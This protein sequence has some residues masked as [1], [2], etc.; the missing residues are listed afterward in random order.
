M[1]AP[2]FPAFAKQF[3]DARHRTSSGRLIQIRPT[4][5]NSGLIAEELTSRAATGQPSGACNQAPGGCQT[6]ELPTL[7][8]PAADH[9]FSAINHGAGQTVIDKSDTTLLAT[10]YVGIAMQREMARC[11]GWPGREIGF[12]DVLALRNEPRGWASCPTAKTEWGQKVLMV[13]SDPFSSSTGRSVLFS[14]YGIA[15]GKQPEALRVDD[16]RDPN[17]LAYI[18]A[19]QSA[20]DHYVPDST[21]V[22]RKMLEGP[23][24][25]QFFFFPENNFVS[26]KRGL[27][28]VQ[29]PG[30]AKPR[31][32]DQDMV[33]IYPKEGAPAN[34]HSA[35]MV[36]ASWVTAEQREAAQQWVNFLLED[37]QQRALVERGFRPA[38]NVPWEDVINPSYGVDPR[39]PTV[40]TNPD[41]VDAAAAQVIL[42]SWGEVKR[43]GVATF[44]VDTSGSMAGAKMDQAKKGM[45]SVLDQI[46]PRNLVGFLTF[47][48]QVNTRVTIGSVTE[49]RYQIRDVVEAMRPSG[50]TALYDAIAEAIA[51]TDAA[52][53]GLDAIRGVVVL[54]DGKAN[55][56]RPLDSVITMS[57]DERPVGSCPA[58]ETGAGCTDQAGRPAKF[59]QILGE[60]LAIPTKHDIHVFFVGIGGDA[61]LQ[62]GRILASATGAT[63]VTTTEKNLSTVLETFGK[64]F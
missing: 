12:S 48:D 2:V 13:Y 30:E 45:I 8:T 59:E 49:N 27:V 55:R 25:G 37:A 36:H 19:F 34:R 23:R 47:S 43:P 46:A 17:V 9:W 21:I 62:V 54:T 28:S 38:A 32:L 57:V 58:F 50:Q 11:L 56:G 41:N 52:E 5:V 42:D 31:G 63:Y 40:I 22:A 15:A 35:A 64:Y 10:T 18:R 29:V 6:P 7:I 44:V 53:P 33:L 4:L 14:L 1:D 20:V 26:L 51:M 24:F 3:N 16:A 61:D 39:K 60:G